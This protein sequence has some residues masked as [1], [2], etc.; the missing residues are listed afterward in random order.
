MSNH[1]L[2]IKATIVIDSEDGKKAEVFVARVFNEAFSKA[3]VESGLVFNSEI[4]YHG[5][6][7]KMKEKD[8]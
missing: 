7:G 5:R 1:V 2:S 8:E 3:R 4:K 6:V